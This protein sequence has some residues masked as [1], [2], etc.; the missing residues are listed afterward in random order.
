MKNS[1]YLTA[2]IRAV[3]A[4]AKAEN[5]VSDTQSAVLA[6]VHLL[7]ENDKPD[8]NAAIA[9]KSALRK[10]YLSHRPHCS[11]ESAGRIIRDIWAAAMKGITDASK[12]PRQVAK[13]EASKESQRCQEPSQN[14]GQERWRERRTD[15]RP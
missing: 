3:S 15:K 9:A 14:T 4:H 7:I 10:E 12:T 6:A 1:V 2:A 11:D 8:R 5:K 13:V